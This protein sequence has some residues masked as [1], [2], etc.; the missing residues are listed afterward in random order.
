MLPEQRSSSGHHRCVTLLYRIP[1]WIFDRVMSRS[2]QNFHLLAKQ[3][4]FAL[5]RAN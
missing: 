4:Y 5:S 1:M 2:I 3:Y